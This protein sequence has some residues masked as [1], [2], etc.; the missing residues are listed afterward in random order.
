MYNGGRVIGTDAHSGLMRF[1]NTQVALACVGIT[2]WGSRVEID[3]F[4]VYDFRL[5]TKVFG[6]VLLHR[7]EATCVT[8]NGFGIADVPKPRGS[9]EGSR[10]D[11]RYNPI[12]GF[13]WY[14]TQQQHTGSALSGSIHSG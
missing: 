12:V 2:H 3:G 7:M 8:G 14:D 5:S 13:E 1:T 10:L 9:F 6:S 11:T 4:E